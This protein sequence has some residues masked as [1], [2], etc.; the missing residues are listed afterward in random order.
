MTFI[1]QLKMSF[2]S[3]NEASLQELEIRFQLVISTQ[4][5]SLFLRSKTSFLESKLFF[6]NQTVVPGIE[7]SFPQL[8][9]RFSEQRFKLSLNK[10]FETKLRMWINFSSCKWSYYSEKEGLIEKRKFQFWKRTCELKL[11]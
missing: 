9:L 7:T 11:E 10:Q 3:R 5:R 4:I 6:R 2:V 8:K 1:F